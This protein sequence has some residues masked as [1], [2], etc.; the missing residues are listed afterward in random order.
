MKK[1]LLFM[2]L[3]VNLQLTTDNGSLSIGFGEVAA[4]SY[5]EEELPEVVVTGNAY[6]ECNLCH[7]K[8]LKRDM[9]QHQGY[10][11]PERLV[12]CD[13]CHK[14][15]KYSEPHTCDAKEGNCV[16]CGKPVDQ[17]TCKGPE[18]QGSGSGSSGGRPSGGYG[19]GGGDSP[20]VTPT[21]TVDSLQ[22]TNK[23]NYPIEELEWAKKFS[24]KIEEIIEH[25]QKA[26]KII[27]KDTPNPQYDS[28]KKSIYLP[29]N[30]DF[31]SESLV[32]E[33]IHY[34]QDS[35]G[36]MNYDINSS[37][38]EYQAYLLNY[39]LQKAYGTVI[40]APM[41]C[42]LYE[43]WSV[44]SDLANEGCWKDGDDIYIGRKLRDA[45][46]N[47]DHSAMSQLFRNQ[48]RSTMPNQKSYYAHHD[49]TYNYNWDSLLNS[50]GVKIK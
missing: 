39:V 25:L 17:C 42:E 49:D 38:I 24:K 4:Q 21:P 9:E 14:P 11:C 1:I 18:I 41:G 26:D 48:Y 43:G 46:Y 50:L 12:T 47:L 8:Y 23:R 15:Y 40:Q 22:T 7:Q 34:L 36:M 37:D 5:W 28:T 3:L 19:G 32:H 2:L 30:T 13:I 29:K 31:T 45:L 16:F 35:L 20:K 27:V 44:F 33:I 10:E 6:E